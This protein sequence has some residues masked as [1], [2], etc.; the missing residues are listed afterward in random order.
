MSVQ[1]KVLLEKMVEGGAAVESLSD[2]QEGQNYVFIFSNCFHVSCQA[3]LGG[4]SEQS[5]LHCV[6]RRACARDGGIRVRLR[7]RTTLYRRWSHL[8]VSSAVWTS[9]LTIALRR[10]RIVSLEKRENW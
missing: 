9:P 10:G 1:G 4:D 3:S 6:S 5:G 8:N 2:D 7:N